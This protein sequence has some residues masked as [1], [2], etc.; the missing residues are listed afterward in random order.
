MQRTF[1]KKKIPTRIKNPERVEMRREQILQAAAKLIQK[2]GYHKTTVRDI[3]KE[4]G[5]SLGNLYD[6][7]TTKEDLLYMV[8]EKAAQIVDS[9]ID[10]LIGDCKD[11]VEKLK[12][13]IEN[14]L[15]T[16]D[17]YQ[18]LIMSIY[19][20]SHSLSKPSLKTMLSSEKAHTEKFEKV[21]KE[22][23]AQGLFRAVNT[24][25]LANVIKIMIDCWVLR[26]W[27]LRS[28]VSLDEMKQGIIEMVQK[29][30]MNQ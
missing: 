1:F 27:I 21:L 4:T 7:I 20:E 24:T 10:K 23:I 11:P 26:R 28:R 22:G 14:E 2:K 18:D 25:L 6:Y 30:I 9:S 12:V 29:G 17:K 16:I 15:Q 13:M 3:S 8:H 5:M 19:Q